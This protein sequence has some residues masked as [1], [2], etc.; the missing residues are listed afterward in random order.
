MAVQNLMLEKVT[1]IDVVDNMHSMVILST[2]KK[3]M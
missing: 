2:L 3:V 1:N